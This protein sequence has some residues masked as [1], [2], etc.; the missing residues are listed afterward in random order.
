MRL[1][2]KQKD[3][4]KRRALVHKE[5]TSSLYAV[6]EVVDKLAK[7]LN[8][9]TVTVYADIKH[10]FK[11]WCD[12]LKEKGEQLDFPITDIEDYKMFFRDNYSPY[13]A[14]VEQIRDCE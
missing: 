6:T 8:I 4:I 12:E 3:L 14:V 7:K 5:Y 10:N 2:R 9:S 1:T 13:E 11:A